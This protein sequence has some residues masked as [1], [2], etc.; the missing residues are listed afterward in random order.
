MH[1]A[2][3][4]EE[5]RQRAQTAAREAPREEPV[6]QETPREEPAREPSPAPVRVDPKVILESA[7]LQMVETSPAKV[8]QS[9]PQPEP[10]Q[11][12]RPRRERTAAVEPV[13]EELVQIETRK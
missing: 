3:M 6:R 13:Q 1:E 10:V 9:V 4:R 5:A 7:G 11:L 2:Q 12:G 8:R